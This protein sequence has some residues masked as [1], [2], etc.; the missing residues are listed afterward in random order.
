[1]NQNSK[2]HLLKIALFATG[3]AGI[4]AEYTLSTLASYFLGN[5]LLQ[6]TLIISVMMFSMGLGSQ[7]SKYFKDKLLEKFLILEFL[8]SIFSSFSAIVVYTVAGL[9]EFTAIIVY[10]LSIIVGLLV[11]MEIPLVTRINEQFQ[12]LRENIS[13]VMAVDYFG[14]LLGGGFFAFIGIPFLG[15]TYTPFVLGA[16]NFLVAFLLFFRFKSHISRFRLFQLLGF[17]VALILAVGI[18]FAKPI[19]MFGEQSRYREKIIYQHQSKYQ[20]IVITQW[21]DHHWLFINGNQ[22]LSSLD[23]WLYHE[24]LVHP[25]MKMANQPKNI[26]I[27]GGGDGCAVREML[28]YPSVEKITMVDLDPKM[29]EI[30][31]SHP[32]LKALNKGAL[33]TEKLTIINQDGFQFL[34]QTKDFYDAIFV[35]LPDPK[36]VDLS[37]LYSKEFYQLCYHQLRPNGAIITQAGSPQF[38]TKAFHCIDITMESAGFSTAPIHNQVLTLGEWGFVIGH[39]SLDKEGLKKALRSLHFDDVK[40]KWLNNDGML[41]ITSFGKSEMDLSTV[42]VNTTSNPMLYHYYLN[43]NWGM[44]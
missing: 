8:L 29:T 41:L 16:I 27:L 5:Q 20:K 17:G 42:K 1:M 11:G 24:P 43:G 38:A 33:E 28:K 18:Y 31:R 39:K 21:K 40:T 44:Y 26:L 37:K 6:W 7:L 25:V 32:V 12:D 9:T 34:E 14:S 4:V 30:G 23:E 36:S 10:L 2:S 19:M 35:D 22:Q 3:F 13:S 15:L